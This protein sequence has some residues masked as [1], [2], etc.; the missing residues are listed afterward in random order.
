MIEKLNK[1]F[2]NRIRLGIMSIL[3]VNDSVD[4]K[5]LKNLLSVT[6][7]NLSSHL[8]ALE[9]IGYLG[10]RKEFVGKRPK[11]SYTITR[12]GLTAFK[13]H[14]SGLENLIKNK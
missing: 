12:I 7:G 5:E 4:F 2:D 14:L 11:S 10:V 6:D 3:S 9:K 1:A 8:S 13:E